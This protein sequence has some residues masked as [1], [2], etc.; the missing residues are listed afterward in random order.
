[1]C[2]D[3][4][5]HTTVVTCYH[6][7]DGNIEKCKKSLYDAITKDSMDILCGPEIWAGTLGPE[8]RIQ[9]DDS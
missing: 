5:V 7:S 2:I 4:I 8:T 9:I 3:I 6:C 1:M